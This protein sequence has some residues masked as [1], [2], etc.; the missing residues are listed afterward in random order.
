MRIAY[1][2]I[3]MSYICHAYICQHLRRTT[4]E[5]RRSGRKFY[6]FY[7]INVSLNLRFADS[8]IDLYIYIICIY[9]Y[10]YIYK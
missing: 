4:D 3:Y 2:V 7:W 1:Y 6:L 9:I 10:I 8:F 5:D